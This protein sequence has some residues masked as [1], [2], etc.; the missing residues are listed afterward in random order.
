MICPNLSIP[1]IRG[2]FN[3]LKEIVGEDF[4]YFLWNR[5]QGHPLSKKVITKNKQE[6]VVDNSIYTKFLEEYQGNEAKATFAVAVTF[7]KKFKTQYPKFDT[8]NSFIQS[9]VVHSYI[10]NNGGDLDVLASKIIAQVNQGFKAET[11]RPEE[12]QQVSREL[13]Q[14]IDEEVDNTID[15]P[16]GRQLLDAYLWFATS[17]LAQHTSYVNMSNIVNQK[18]FAQWTKSAITLYRGSDFTDLYHEAFHEFTQKFLTK[19]EKAAL[20]NMIQSRPGTISLGGVELPYYSLTNRQIEEVLAE[21]FRSYGLAK[22]LEVEEPELELPVRNFF[23][24]VMDFLR[25]LFTKGTIVTPEGQIV[26]QKAPIDELFEKLYKGN[27]QEYEYSEENIQ[28]SKLNRSKALNIEVVDNKGNKIP[29]EY[30]SL[31][32]AEILSAIDYYFNTALDRM[33]INASFFNSNEQKAKIIPQIYDQVRTSIESAITNYKKQLKTA[34]P[35]SAEIIEERINSLVPLVYNKKG[36]DKWPEIVAYHKSFS[37][38]NVLKTSSDEE[39]KDTDEKLD[40][41]NEEDR[42]RNDYDSKGKESINPMDLASPEILE[43]IKTLPDLKR[44]EK[45]EV[46]QAV[47]DILGLPLVGDFLTNK[48]LILNKVSGLTNYQRAIEVLMEASDLSPQLQYFINRMPKTTGALSIAEE[49]LKAQFMQFASMPTVVPM[50]IKATVE[51]GTEKGA[52]KLSLKASTFMENTLSQGSLIE[53]FDQDFVEN[54]SR[55]YRNTDINDINL[56]TFDIK[57]VLDDYEGLVPFTDQVAFRFFKE[58]FG[59]DLYANIP[60][61]TLFNRKGEFNFKVNPKISP[62][63]LKNINFMARKAIDKMTLVDEINRSNIK[64]LKDVVPGATSGPLA[65]WT[66]DISEKLS[67]AIKNQLS[68]LPA[69]SKIRQIYES[70]KGVTTYKNERRNFY[71]TVESFNNL[72]NSA[73]YLSIENNLE[74]SIREWNHMLSTVEEINNVNNISEL[75]GHLNMEVNN[76]PRYSAWFKRIFDASGNRRLNQA[77]EPVT[78]EVINFSGM[79][80]GDTT[81]KKTTNLSADSKLVQDFLGFLKDATFENIRVGAKSS[82]F[83]TR[84]KGNISERTFFKRDEFS[85]PDGKATLAGSVLT[86]M[87]DYLDF[88]ISRMYDDRAKSTPKEVRG[89]NFIIFKDI[90]P[91]DLQNEIKA[92]VEVAESKESL[93]NGIGTMFSVGRDTKYGVFVNSVEAFYNSQ[94]STFRASLAEIISQGKQASFAVEFSKLNYDSKVKYNDETVN[95]MILHYLANYNVSQIEFVHTIIGDPSNFNVDPENNNWRE[96]FK[97]LGAAISPGKQPHL[98]DQTMLSWNTDPNYGRLLEKERKGSARVYDENFKYVQ[99]KDIPSFTLEQATV[100]RKE[101]EDGF[102]EWKLSLLPKNASKVKKA[103]ATKAAV[104][105]IR[106]NL[107]EMFKQKKEADAQAYANLDFIRFYLNSIG[108]WNPDLEDAYKHEVKVLKAIQAYRSNKGTKQEVLDLINQAN[109]GILTS[110]KLGYYGSPLENS[111]YVA[112]GKYSVFNLL[113]SA[114]FDTDLEGFM[115]DMFDKGVD[116]ATFDSGNKMSSPVESLPF[117][118]EGDSLSVTSIPPTSVLTFPIKGLRRQQYIAPKFKNEATLS[119]Q[120]VKLLFGDFYIDGQINP[121][122]AAIQGKMDALQGTFITMVQNVVNAEK[123]KIYTQIEA[124]TNSEGNITSFSV[125]AFK[126]WLFKEFDKKDIPN[127]VYLYIDSL[128]ESSFAR[129]L[130]GSAQRNLVESVITSALSKR[131]LRPKMFGEAYIQLASSG[132][133]NLGTRFTKP[134]AEQVAEYGTS[135]L[136]DYRIQNG[137]TQPAD[138]KISFNPKKH[139]ALLNLTWNGQPIGTLDRLNKALMDTAWV[140]QHSAK[141]TI[142]GVRIPVQGF[143]SMEYFRVRQFLPTSAGPVIIVP[144][145]I[146]TK[147]GSDFDID[148]LFMYE[149]KLDDEGNIIDDA[150]VDSSNFTNDMLNSIRERVINLQSKKEIKELLNNTGAYFVKGLYEQDIKNLKGVLYDL[151]TRKASYDDPLVEGAHLR[152]KMLIARIEDLKTQNPTLVSTLNNLK[153]INEDLNGLQAYTPQNIKNISSNRMIGVI[154]DV[155][156]EP[157]LYSRFT[158]PN[159]N[160]ILPTIADRYLKMRG[161]GGKITASSMFS[162]MTSVQIFNENTLGKKSLGVDA[163]V[164]AL[165][166]L[167]Q[168]TG[169]RLTDNFLTNNY[170]LKSN[171]DKNGSIILGGHLDADGVNL[172]S[173]V[174]NEFINGHVDIEKEDWINYFNADKARTPLILQM[175]LNGTP[176]EDAILLVNQPIVQHF[177]RSSKVGDVG[178]SLGQKSKKANSYILNNLDLLEYPRIMMEDNPNMVDMDKTISMIL[179]EDYFNKHLLNFSEANYP[180]YVRNDR[181]AF[182]SIEEAAKRGDVEAKSQLAAQIA[183]LTQFMIVKEQNE[184]LLKLTSNVDFNTN[185]YRSI[186]DFFSTKY[187]IQEARALFNDEAVDKIL[188][189]SVVSP[190]NIVNDALSISNQLFDVVNLPVIQDEI[191]EWL[192]TKPFWGKERKLKAVN[193]AFNGFMHLL[194]QT[195]GT[196]KSRAIYTKYGKDSG[197]LDKSSDKNLKS[198]FIRLFRDSKNPALKDFGRNNLFLSNFTTTDIKDNKKFYITMKTNEKDPDTVDAVQKAYMDGLNHPNPEVSQFFSNV[199]NATIVSQGFNI[200]Y[201]SIQPYLPIQSY[202]DVAAGLSDTLKSMK[203]SYNLEEN[204]IDSPIVSLLRDHMDTAIKLTE[205]KPKNEVGKFFPIYSKEEVAKLT[206]T[207]NDDYLPGEETPFLGDP[208]VF[209]SDDAYQQDNLRAPVMESTQMTVARKVQPSTSVK[210]NFQEEPTSGYKNRTIKNASADAT[211]ALAYDFTSAGEKLTKSSVLNQNKKYI[212][213]SIP[214]KTETSDVDNAPIKTIVDSVVEKLNSV[215]ATTLNIAG[216][217]IYTMRDAGWNQEEVDVMTYRVLKGIVESPNLINKIVSIRS[218]GQTGFDEAGAKAGIKL[219][220]PTTILA[221]KGWK[222]RN[223]SGTDISNEQAFKARFAS[224]QPSTTPSKTDSETVKCRTRN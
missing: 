202:I 68:D 213:L 221:P 121:Q 151:S 153:A 78:L 219:G 169:L 146:V 110:L 20:Y 97:R 208:D 142:V 175:V 18:A 36:Q 139:Q 194:I 13:L 131:V 168:Q 89:F 129:S 141:I 53:F 80:I 96:L 16:T 172:I 95:A 24:K 181:K 50:N 184:S 163:K 6:T 4:A 134:T 3:S 215:N 182:D 193:T 183:F 69:T 209:D 167:F 32:G 154:S 49:A 46:I 90:L 87:R 65:T 34:D 57:S 86:Q 40:D 190:F 52:P 174:I 56:P 220:I 148:K 173:D 39:T 1:S 73:S 176:I 55:R 222:F 108:E 28:N 117:Y 92:L 157:A 12:L 14:Q 216:N 120:L 178:I 83:A 88:E 99:F 77:G 143:N 74:W 123:A 159:A 25:S 101:I 160:T 10:S 51:K 156:S 15:K 19:A 224:T 125:P 210:I 44:N 70:Y 180:P 115:L 199:A 71:N 7:S 100:L 197:F 17:P 196:D 106:L 192:S 63:A 186:T 214:R 27:I 165:H 133:N 140:A 29:I 102:V 48:N 211:I 91:E 128:D 107:D 111:K 187:G 161:T 109:K 145:S 66:S 2:E 67:R 84:I 75:A 200:R 155:L 150:I 158:K 35:A 124:E 45:G 41:V 61:T 104:E 43:L 64:D 58:V 98:D 198:E 81:G 31:E 138:I 218:G 8:F 206:K 191:Q 201:R 166:K 62:L 122:F 137:K 21:E 119:T 149:P 171:K 127:S 130:D 223:E 76:F 135:G 79:Q 116:F 93:L 189:N 30:S 85:T 113:P 112:L 217:G 72:S 144:P 132:F 177:L 47:G 185:S 103:E 33:G 38:G 37:K 105:E 152:I 22:S 188:N 82:S 126:N 5:N 179:G 54:S 11:F 162:P 9:R 26:E 204:K 170:Y 205:R 94:L 114:V 207:Y 195:Y 212:P 147:S 59:I 23:Q 203:E 118:K 164:N 60:E 136:R 42:S